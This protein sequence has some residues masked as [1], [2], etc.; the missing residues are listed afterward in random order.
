MLSRPRNLRS[1]LRSILVPAVALLCMHALSLVVF[2]SHAT[3][4]SYP[5]LLLAPVAAL[6]VC[7]HRARTI[8]ARA[9]LPWILLSAS[10]LLWTIGMLLSAWEELLR[11]IPFD[12]AFFSDFVFF[13]YGVPVLLAISAPTESSTD[14]PPTLLFLSLDAIQALL[15]AYLTY[16]TLFAVLPFA[17]TSIHPISYTLLTSV[18][19][20]E[21]LVLAAAATLRLLAQPRHAPHTED[22]RFFQTLCLFLWTYALCA[23]LYNYVSVAAAPHTLADLLVDLP[24]LLLFAAARLPSSSP[25]TTAP[26]LPKTQL[27]LFID[28]ASPIF[29][30]LALLAL[31]ALVARQHFVIGIAAILVALAVYGIRTTTLQS[32][33]LQSQH[34]LQQVRDQLQEMSLKDG[35]TN[36]ANRRCFDQILE[37]EWGR[38]IRT[39]HPLSLL[40]IDVDFF[41]NINDRYGHR[42]GDQCL[43]EIATALHSTL[44]R[45]CDLLARYGGEEFAAILPDTDLTGTKAV[46][47]RMQEAVRALH[48][49][50]QTAIGHFATVSIGIAVYEFPQAGDPAALIE[51]SDRGLYT[52]KQNGRD[53]I[54]HAPLQELL[55]AGS[56]S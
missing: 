15:T 5:F 45:S 43:L 27:A 3:A 16:I 52:A 9:R 34:D 8:P 4:A 12:I 22:R 26:P 1:N 30:T 33:F 25:D 55:D 11:N 32:R 13:L 36:V 28:N 31:G 24:F 10:L 6:F 46:A 50:N 56:F 29:Y 19:N 23:G 39:Q 53:R 49:P 21:N 38:A 42:Y 35:L 41:K 2:R 48:I 54:A 40:L 51:A 47:D 7:A 44:P 17:T 14:A 20:V 37:L 18:Y